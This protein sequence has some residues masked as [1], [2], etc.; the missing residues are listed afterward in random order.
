MSPERKEALKPL[1]SKW[2]DIPLNQKRKW[3]AVADKIPSMKPDE[4]ARVQKNMADWAKLTPDQRRQAREN[5]KQVRDLPPEQR[6]AISQQYKALPEQQKKALAKEADNKAK[7]PAKPGRDEAKNGP[8]PKSAKPL[9][10]A[11]ASGTAATPPAASPATAAPASGTPAVNAPAAP[12]GSA[13]NSAS[14]PASK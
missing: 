14:A 9:A 1:E 7:P 6:Q 5:F 8:V 11:P 13:G 12:T 10:P 4:K 2:E 3:L